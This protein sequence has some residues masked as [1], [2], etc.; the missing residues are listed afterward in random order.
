MPYRKPTLVGWSSRPRRSGEGS[1]RNSAKKLDVS[2]ARCPTPRKRGHSK[3][4]FRDC[5][6]K[7]QV[8]ANSKETVYGL[9]PAQCSQVKGRGDSNLLE[10]L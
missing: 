9:R 5:L 7:T 8:R 3:R 4:V 10:K 2:Y 6:T 1:S